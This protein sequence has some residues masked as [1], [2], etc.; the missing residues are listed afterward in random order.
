MSNSVDGVA[1]VLSD[2]MPIQLKRMRA[3]GAR[4]ARPAGQDGI[5]QNGAGLDRASRSNGSY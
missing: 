3:P 2:G 4:G 5:G 1:H